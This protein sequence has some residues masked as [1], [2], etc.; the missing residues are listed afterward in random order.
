MFWD[1]SRWIDERAHETGLARA[2]ATSNHR[3]HIA[4]LAAAILVGVAALS[5]PSVQP[6]AASYQ[7]RVLTAAWGTNYTMDIVQESAKPV[8]THGTWR[9]KTNARFLGGHVLT[10]WQRG[11][12][13][14]YSFTGSGI[15]IV[16]PTSRYRGNARISIDGRYVKT[17][18]SHASRYQRKVTLFAT[19][20]D[21]E[22]THTITVTV[23]GK[24][25]DTKFSVDAFVVRHLKA[26]GRGL[27]TPAPQTTPTPTT[28]ASPT[29]D[30]AVTSTAAPTPTKAPTAAPTPIKA[31][32]ATPTPTKAP[33]AAPTPTK[34]PTAA[35]TPTKAPT[36][37]ATPASSCG[38][39]LQA[40]VDAA[41][42][43]GTLNLAGCKYTAGATIS[44]PLTLVGA[45]VRPP[46]GGTGIVVK[47]NDV[48]L[49]GLRIIGPQG[50]TYRE[51]EFGITVAASASSPA[52]RL[53]IRNSEVASFGKAG[54][55]LRYVA[56]LVIED[57][58]VHDT[59]Y[60]G[61]MVISGTGGRISG[62]TVSRI[63]VTGAGANSNNAYGI[64]LEDQGLPVSSDLVVANNLV[65]D[66]PTWHALDTHGGHRIT[67]R[68]NT[69][70]RSSRG[71]FLTSSE[72][73]GSK[74]TDITVAGNQIMG[75]DPVTFNLTPI[76]LYAVDGATFTSNTISGWGSSS[77]TAAKP[78]YDY[79][80]KSTGLTA[81][82]NTVAP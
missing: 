32:T 57:N 6:A 48:T 38:S 64:A 43:G 3:P 15:A 14:S 70:R 76:T 22:Q 16:G 72:A 77:P 60:A 53:T 31:P 49:D 10:S 23:L 51:G 24:T 66:V 2:R 36:P 45:T 25:R 28:T 71:L 55:W 59:V 74:A 35:P 34:A 52:R 61:I 63:G 11:A 4:V 19:T 75:P 13:I 1:G 78:Y 39:S 29:S 79:T 47:A 44:K 80:G 30:P 8:A 42:S 27:R 20:W 18:N 17:V 5:V 58:E 21:T 7:S 68:D 33:T 73:S 56:D 81:S 12:T 65:T 69:V 82:G 46:A 26:R 41:P 37:T 67:F 54:M 40:K 9:R 50:A 62:N